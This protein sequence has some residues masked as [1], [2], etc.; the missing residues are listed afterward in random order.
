MGLQSETANQANQGSFPQES[1]GICLN[2]D[3]AGRE[4]GDL[5]DSC[6]FIF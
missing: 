2:A 6:F 4:P 3:P 1:A 5:S